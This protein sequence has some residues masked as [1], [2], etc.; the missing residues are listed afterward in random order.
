MYPFWRPSL[1]SRRNAAGGM[2]GGWAAAAQFQQPA[3]WDL[4]TPCV[5]VDARHDAKQFDSDEGSGG[6]CT[7]SAGG[8]E[9]PVRDGRG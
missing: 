8:A 6:L 3:S 2:E 9:R 7:F 4:S 5:S 1:L